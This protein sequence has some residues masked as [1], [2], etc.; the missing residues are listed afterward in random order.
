[1]LFISNDAVGDAMGGNAIRATELARVVA[2]RADVTLAAP[3]GPGAAAIGVPHVPF[4]P[5][6]PARLRELIAAADIVVTPPQSAQ[7]AAWLGRAR[8]TLIFDLYDPAP[9]EALETFA[10]APALRRW[11]WN[12]LALD[13]TL[14][15][16]HLGNRFL[17]ASERQRD[18]WLG[19]MLAQRLITPAV[20]ERDPSLR[21]VIDVVPFGVAETPPRA[22]GAGG[23]RARFPALGDDAEIVL[24]NGGIWNWLDPVA[25][26]RAVAQLA[27]RRP[28]AR[29]VFMGRPPEEPT[30]ARAATE[31]RA[32]AEQLGV[33]DR[34]VFF[35]DAWVP[36]AERAD[37]LLEAACSVS[38]HADHVEA[39]FA[40]RTRVLDCV[41]AGLPVV[42]SDGDDLAGL[43]AREDLGA[44]A[45]P[46]DTDA[47]AAGLERVLGRGKDA[48]AGA[49][50][51][52]A[53]EL[54]WPRVAAPLVRY[55][56]AAG[57]PPRLGAGWPHRI[58]R[59]V[60][61]L[62]GAAIR[63]ARATRDGLHRPS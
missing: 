55:V 28:A 26:V 53:E 12:T 59:P 62:R 47:V 15:A 60:A 25:A 30:A 3:S 51:A 1:M 6:R 27:E 43:I 41:W 35:N 39:R 21:D 38:T 40:F 50:S 52:A 7:V 36:Y 14:N 49:M 58:A 23:P 20:R 9:F 24:W 56:A 31:A 16:L 33:L 8:A 48:Y 61:R 34:S 45:P 46:G 44:V 11:G 5:Q 54:A 37:W 22:T 17:C 29:L 2:R 10:D 57:P 63:A 42:C 18:L 32:L 19:A 13:Q 4:D